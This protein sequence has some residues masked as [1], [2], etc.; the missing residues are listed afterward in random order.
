MIPI[1]GKLRLCFRR[2]GGKNRGNRIM[3]RGGTGLGVNYRGFHH[4]SAILVYAAAGGGRPALRYAKARRGDHP[5]VASF[6]RPKANRA[7]GS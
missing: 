1:R 2:I 4:G 7:A 6:K 3:Y 5:P